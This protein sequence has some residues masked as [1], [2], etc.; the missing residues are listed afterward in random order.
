MSQ[1]HLHI[2][3]KCLT[4]FSS[5]DKVSSKYCP[6]CGTSIFPV[7]VD[8]DVYSSLTPTQKVEWKKKYVADHYPESYMKTKEE[9]TPM[10]PSGWVTYIMVFGWLCL[11][12]VILA[13]TFLLMTGN[14]LFA[15]LTAFAGLASSG[16]LILFAIVAEDVRHIRNRVDRFHHYNQ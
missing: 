7:D 3:P 2:C 11:I 9:F 1:K 15:I 5:K 13:S 4:F 12:C 8:Y 16:A 14:I 10:P 6:E